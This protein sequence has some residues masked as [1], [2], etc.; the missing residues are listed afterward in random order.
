VDKRAKYIDMSLGIRER[1]ESLRKA[2]QQ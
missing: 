2:K 1:I